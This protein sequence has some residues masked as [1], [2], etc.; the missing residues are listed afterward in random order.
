MEGG[1]TNIAVR[2]VGWQSYIKSIVVGG[3][4]GVK[5]AGLPFWHFVT[6]NPKLVATVIYGGE[7]VVGP[8][9]AEL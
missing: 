8:D 2:L 6:T 7:V 9:M 4:P 1:C 5:P 3:G